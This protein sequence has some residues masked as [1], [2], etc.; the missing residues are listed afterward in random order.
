DPNNVVAESNKG[1]NACN[2]TVTEAAAPTISKA[3][4]ATT[5]PVGGTTSL[6]F[7]IFNPNSNVSLTGVGFMDTLPGGLSTPNATSSACGGGTLT[8][9]NN[10][11]SLSGGT[12]AASGS[13]NFS[14]NVT[15]TGAGDQSN[16]TGKVS[17]NE[18]GQGGTSNT[19]T[20]TVVAPPTISKA[21]GA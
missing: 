1:N 14:V 3:F 4:G 8:G 13:C 10:V 12:L 5:I 19:A 20:I 18:S 17:S 2:D 9:T 15:G 21:F 7:S 16:I 6:S 11:I